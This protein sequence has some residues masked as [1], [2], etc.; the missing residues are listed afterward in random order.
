MARPKRRQAKAKPRQQGRPHQ[1]LWFILGLAGLAALV[2]IIVGIISRA[3]QR[4][5]TASAVPVVGASGKGLGDPNAPVEVW[6]FSD[7][8][9]PHCRTF[10]ET[11]EKQL[12]EEY[13]K[14]GR[15][16]LVYKHFIVLQ[17]YQAANASECAAEQGKF[18]EYH[19]YLFAKQETDAPFTPDELKRYARELGL[20]TE[21][22]DRCVDSGKYMNVVLQETNEG[23]RLGVR[24]TPT[25]FVN[26]QL[27]PRGALWP[28]LKAA[29]EAALQQ[30]GKGG[31]P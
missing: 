5:Q 9:C 26:G 25:I 1:R 10:A 17:S 12:I 27:V 28:D 6:D 22:F 14:P 21:A 4:P 24:G 16:R 7:F 8:H 3:G 19:D 18:W 23:R 15:A 29:I 20:D 30:A 11:T 31:Q 13:I 2:L